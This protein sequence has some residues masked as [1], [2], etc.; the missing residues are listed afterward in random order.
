M[1]K[2]L[3]WRL[4]F[5][6]VLLTT[7]VYTLSAVF[8]IWLFRVE[9]TR[10]MDE[11]LHALVD[12]LRPAIALKDKVPNLQEWAKT[13]R[14]VPFKFLPTIQIYD[15]QGR[16]IEQHGPSGVPILFSSVKEV[17]AEDY[18][19]RVCSAPL[20]D[21]KQLAGYLQLQLS[22]RNRE[23]AIAQFGITMGLIFPFLL[24]A[25]AIAGYVFAGKAASPVE[26]SFVVLRRFM[27]DAGHEL[28]TPISIIQANAEAMEVE[29]PE[30]VRENNRLAVI[31]RSTERM[32]NL[33]K[34]LM[35]L[36]KMES[37]QIYS[38]KIPLDF[39]KLVRGVVEEFQELFKAKSITLSTKRVGPATVVG[40][41]EL[42]KRLVT[43]LLQNA[44]RYT[45]SSGT[46]EIGVES[47]GRNTRLTVSDTGVGIPPESLQSI[48][49]RF[50]RVDKSR[51][52]N[53]GGAGLGLSIVKAIVDAHRGRI[54]VYS[55][56]G[57]GST[58]TV[59]LP[60]RI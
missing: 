45:E 3:R 38:N 57:T 53:Q 17:R 56:V 19:I 49:E 13:A 21:G 40:D 12:E 33:V 7:I 1:F 6:F 59:T 20:L 31:T 47:L 5:W 28:S 23:R 58:F 43:N 35:L 9:M 44:L 34:D 11:E 18:H 32:A 60:T 36:S 37:P 8:A 26:E 30:S 46:V 42:L 48:F 15:L 16:L 10:V 41:A 25:L 51:S 22:L 39:E 50:Y 54:D 52:R 24:L 27:T 4:T 29:I 55:Q 14:Q 2:S